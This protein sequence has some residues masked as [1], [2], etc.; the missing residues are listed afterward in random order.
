MYYSKTFVPGQFSPD[1]WEASTLNVLDSFTVGK[2]IGSRPVQPTVTMKRTTSTL[3]ADLDEVD[4]D[5][6]NLFGKTISLVEY[7]S[8]V[9]LSSTTVFGRL[10]YF[11][12][13]ADARFNEG[14]IL[15]GGTISVAESSNVSVK[16]SDRYV[17]N[18]LSTVESPELP[19][20][21]STYSYAT[22]LASIVESKLAT[23]NTA[24]KISFDIDVIESGTLEVV[25]FGLVKTK[26]EERLTLT[27]KSINGS[28]SEARTVV[29]DYTPTVQTASLSNYEL[30]AYQ[31]PNVTS[32]ETLQLRSTRSAVG[33]VKALAIESVN[34]SISMEPS[35]VTYGQNP[36]NT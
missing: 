25:Q 32:V 31:N 19:M 23:V 2:I 11:S 36:L 17:S 21:A 20:I 5:R 30:A 22:T 4:L 27:D 28:I 9:K 7:P 10:L 8:E 1:Y 35:T 13:E 12:E 33:E 34:T 29:L 3:I 15:T 24:P 26:L 18:K 6:P 16:S 14:I